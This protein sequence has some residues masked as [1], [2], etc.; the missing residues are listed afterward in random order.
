M[1]IHKLVMCPSTKVWQDKQSEIITRLVSEYGV[2]GVYMDQT[3]S[4][5]PAYCFDPTHGH[6]IGGGSYWVEGNRKMV[7]L[8]KENAR[9]KNPRDDSHH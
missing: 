4:C 5:Q 3:A 9:K 7:E 1:E 2:D 6:S 8:C